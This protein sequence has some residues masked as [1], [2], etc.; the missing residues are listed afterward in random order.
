[1]N[2]QIK[3]LCKVM[4]YIEQKAI[5]CVSLPNTD[6]EKEVYADIYNQA[7]RQ[8]GCF[9]IEY[10]EDKYVPFAIEAIKEYELP[11][12]LREKIEQSMEKLHEN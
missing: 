6:V 1:M 9:G 10:M 12:H 11:E 7:I 4:Y 5:E 2:M 8:A 3:N